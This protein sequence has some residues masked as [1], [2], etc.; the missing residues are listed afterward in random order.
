MY[1]YVLIFER[2]I[3]YRVYIS[4]SFVC[5][6]SG[7]V[8]TLINDPVITPEVVDVGNFVKE[9]EMQCDIQLNEE[10]VIYDIYWYLDDRLIQKDLGL[11]VMSATLSENKIK[12]GSWVSKRLNYSHRRDQP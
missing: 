2:A 11:S 6:I 5:T 4:C 3:L 1:I 8:P 12:I 7:A 10:N 9:V